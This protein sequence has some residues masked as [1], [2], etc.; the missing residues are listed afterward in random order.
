MKHRTLALI[1]LTAAFAGQSAFAV[2]DEAKVEILVVKGQRLA[3][4]ELQPIV[5]VAET[6]APLD[7]STL[8]LAPPVIERPTPALEPP[9][10]DSPRIEFAR[11]DD[12]SEKG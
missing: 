6:R 11:A 7:L 5:D 9:R 12:G 1:A 4:S 3:E 2:A 10:I 8:E